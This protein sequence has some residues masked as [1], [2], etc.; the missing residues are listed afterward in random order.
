ME[1]ECPMCGAI[2]EMVDPGGDFAEIYI[3]EEC[4]WNESDM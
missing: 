2:I 1:K 3:C 4:G